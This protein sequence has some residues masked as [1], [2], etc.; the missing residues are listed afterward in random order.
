MKGVKMATK[1]CVQSSVTAHPQSGFNNWQNLLRAQLK[2]Q[3]VM[4]KATEGEFTYI[5]E[6]LDIFKHLFTDQD[7]IKLIRD[8]QTEVHH[9]NM[10]LNHMK[11]ELKPFY[12]DDPDTRRHWRVYFTASIV[13]LDR[14]GVESQLTN[15]VYQTYRKLYTLHT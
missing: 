14:N 7:L 2:P 10:G 13:R 5:R 4:R 12:D 8:N 1:V 9:M 15:L 6:H 3:L 11:I